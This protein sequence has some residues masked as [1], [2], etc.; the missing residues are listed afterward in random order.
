MC[1]HLFGC[2]QLLELNKCINNV[3]MYASTTMEQ[4]LDTKKSQDEDFNLGVLKHI[5]KGVRDDMLV[6]LANKKTQS[7]IYKHAMEELAN[8]MNI[9][10][11]NDNKEENSSDSSSNSEGGDK[12]VA[13]TKDMLGKLASFKI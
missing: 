9:D 7:E 6:K 13:I 4:S 8:M 12:R 2:N 11:N 3:V 10:D 5:L 1:E